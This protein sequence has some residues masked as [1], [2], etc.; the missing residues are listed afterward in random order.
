MYRTIDVSDLRDR[1]FNEP[2]NAALQAISMRVAMLSPNAVLIHEDDFADFAMEL[3]E[4]IRPEAL[5]GT[6][7]E[8]VERLRSEYCWIPVEGEDYLYRDTDWK[9]ASYAGSYRN[10]GLVSHESACVL[11]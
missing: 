11:Y 6:M 1:I 3:A 2:D 9:L 8:T 7:E 5:Y 10:H 4:T